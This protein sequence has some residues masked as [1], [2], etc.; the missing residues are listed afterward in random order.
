M[1]VRVRINIAALNAGELY[2][3]K[4]YDLNR[5]KAGVLQLAEGC[6]MV[7]DETGMSDG[8]LSERGLKNVKAIGRVI[9]AGVTPIDFQYYEA[10]AP[11]GCCTVL[12]SKGGKSIVGGDVV[13]K[14]VHGLD[15]LVGWESYGKEMLNKL[16]TMLGLLTED[17]EFDIEEE[18]SRVIEED[19][20]RARREGRAKDGQETLQGWLAVARS[21]AR[22]FGERKLTR[23]RWIYARELEEKRCVRMKA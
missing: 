15:G 20:V 17:G 5:V 4:D 7:G 3:K 13:V 11:V 23:E 18:T 19:Y 14:V 9:G 2:P 8:R 12:M 16:R 6:V 1:V 21:C 10:E 22:S